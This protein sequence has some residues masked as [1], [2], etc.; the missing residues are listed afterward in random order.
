MKQVPFQ[1]RE[2]LV[3]SAANGFVSSEMLNNYLDQSKF[4]GLVILAVELE[5]E[6][7]IDDLANNDEFYIQIV[8]QEF[9]AEAYRDDRDVKFK[10]KQ[11]FK[12]AAAGT[13]EL[14]GN[15]NWV[16]GKSCIIPTE[17]YWI[18]FQ[19]IG[20]AGA[21]TVNVT[22]DCVMGFIGQSTWNKITSSN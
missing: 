10:R 8:T 12:M 1:I 16:L 15:Y 7:D 21:T 5:F 17:K 11:R 14:K 22:L 6:T 2:Q 9:S 3:P 4:K 20:Q 19:T 18:Q 13:H